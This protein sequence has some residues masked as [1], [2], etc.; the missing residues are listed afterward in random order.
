MAGEDKNISELEK[1]YG[2]MAKKIAAA[3]ATNLLPK[4]IAKT[5]STFEEKAVGI[6][7]AF[8]S[9]RDRVV[10]MKSSMADAMVSVKLL[11]GSMEDVGNIA[12]KVGEG[13][14]RNIILTSDAYSK[15]YATSK[16][17][18]VQYETLIPKFKDAGLSVYQISQ[19]M[20]KVVNTA[21]ES[22]VNAKTVSK[23][24]VENLSMMDKFN[25]VGGVEGMA[26]MVTQAANLRI[27]VQSIEIMLDKAF[28]PESAIQ[29]AAALQRLGVAQS[30]LLDPLRLMD[31]SRNDPTEFTRQI[32]EMSKQFVEFNRQT[33]SFEI[34][35]GAKEQ[36]QEVATELGIS[37]KELAKMARASA[38][39]D[40]KLKKITFP[41]TFTEEQ[42]K[43]VANMAEM[44]EGGQYMLRVDN[45][46]LKLDEA[47]KLFQEQPKLYEK[48][49]KETKEP[50]TMEE[51]AKDQLTITQ[52][53]DANIAAIG[54]RMGAAIASSETYETGNQ[55]MVE[56][57]ETIPKIFSGEKFQVPTMREGMDNVT[58]D[59]LKA[60]KS[61]DVLGGL[62]GMEDK[63]TNYFKDAFQDAAKGGK[64]AFDDLSK[65]TNPLIG[66]FLD[67][68][69][70]VK[71]LEGF[72]AEEV[73]ESKTEK[74]ANKTKTETESEKLKV[75]KAI[76]E[77]TT[78]TKP[79]TETNEIKF[80]QPLKIEISLTG[81]QGLSET[82]LRDLLAEGKLSQELAKAIIEATKQQIK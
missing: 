71:E 22:G 20:E 9:S 82:Q 50:K 54:E 29:M 48:F 31:L 36:L 75:E 47:M 1:A 10:E 8:G 61:G 52:R 44:G 56:L 12:S 3:F 27:S 17:T 34:A 24:V 23:N 51:L 79:K 73:K 2:G 53:T 7:N 67:L 59:L 62:G 58:G 4:E 68:T 80:S 70:N 65:S 32:G 76:E 15:L 46:D 28:K 26:K 33:K 64:E 40:D 69:K 21:L 35:P 13:L 81:T 16:V 6:I 37:Y 14:G 49:V 55:A 57:S 19:N 11:G 77:S 66:L 63:F 41:D 45:K 5:L 60:Y 25:F 38:E 74:S 39:L 42:K 43:F 78:Q 72:T 30:D 18:G